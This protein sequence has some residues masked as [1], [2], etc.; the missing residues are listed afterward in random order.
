MAKG[1]DDQLDKTAE[2]IN[3]T[4]EKNTK[5]M[6]EAGAKSKE[7]E[8]GVNIPGKDKSTEASLDI[9][10]DSLRDPIPPF[11]AIRGNVFVWMRP[12]MK[13]RLVETKADPDNTKEKDEREESEEDE[14]TPN[15]QRVE[16]HSQLGMVKGFTTSWTRP[17]RRST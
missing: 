4:S 1:S 11:L 10:S 13:Q 16:T 8:A 12:D 2:E 17:W 9:I 15:T 14:E 7:G 6:K 3:L 5:N